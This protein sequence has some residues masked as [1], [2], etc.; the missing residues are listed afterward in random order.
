LECPILP[1]PAPPSRPPPGRWLACSSAPAPAPG[2]GRAVWTFDG[3]EVAHATLTPGF[4]VPMYLLINLVVGGHGYTREMARAGVK[5]KPWE[6]NE[7]TMPWKM[8]CD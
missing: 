1:F 5:V 8:Q 2:I 4:H 3:K 7:S 6:V